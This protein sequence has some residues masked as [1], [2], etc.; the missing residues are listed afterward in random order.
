[1]KPKEQKKFLKVLNAK[2]AA[3]KIMLKL[4]EWDH[5]IIPEPCADRNGDIMAISSS[6]PYLSFYI[7]WHFKAYTD[8]QRDPS[9]LDRSV[10][11]ELTHMLLRSLYHTGTSRY[12]TESQMEDEYERTT[13]HVSK[14]IFDLVT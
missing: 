9:T 8:W 1:M 13:E 2:V 14:V 10:L 12:V 6:H 7:Y 5:Q 4:T 3:Y 11:H